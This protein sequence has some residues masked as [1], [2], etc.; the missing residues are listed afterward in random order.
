MQVEAHRRLTLARLP[1]VLV[2]HLKRF[3]FDK[4]GGSQ[5]LMKQ[6]QCS[7]DLVI[8]KGEYMYVAVSAQ[9]HVHRWTVLLSPEMNVHKV[10]HRVCTCIY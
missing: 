2:L 8:R 1:A 5:K 4:T 6:V 3:L 10:L 9:L 7:L